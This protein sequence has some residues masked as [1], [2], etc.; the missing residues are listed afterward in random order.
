MEKEQLATYPNCTFRTA[1]IDYGQDIFSTIVSI[2][3]KEMTQYEVSTLRVI[4]NDAERNYDLLNTPLDYIVQTTNYACYISTFAFKI[5]LIDRISPV[6]SRRI[7]SEFKV[8]YRDYIDESIILG[9]YEITD[10]YYNKIAKVRIDNLDSILSDHALGLKEFTITAEDY[11]GNKTILN[12]SITIFDDVAPEISGPSEIN[13][14]LGSKVSA[15]EITGYFSAYD[16]LDKNLAVTLKGPGRLNSRIGNYNI[17]V[18]A[19]DFSGNKATKN[20][21]VR[22]NEK[23]TPTYTV[24]EKSITTFETEV[25]SEENILQSLVRNGFL[26]EDRKY[27]KAVISEGDYLVNPRQVGQ[28]EITLTVT[29]ADYD[30][31]TFPYSI[32]VLSR[33][34]PKARSLLDNICSSINQIWI[35]LRKFFD[36]I[37]RTRKE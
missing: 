15:E 28:H 26:P 27:L 32:T 4:K 29:T 35:E 17:T 22:V 2:L 21:L 16:E 6:I 37:F 3:S 10:N 36:K 33:H 8:S 11:S 18:Q 12:D 14:P 7:D 24:S 31:I 13:I 25:L 23:N 5:K 1:D 9:K 34:K 30:D 20:C 19:E